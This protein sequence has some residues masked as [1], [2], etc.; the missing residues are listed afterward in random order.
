[1]YFTIACVIVGTG[2][3]VYMVFRKSD[4][5]VM[6]SEADAY[7]IIEVDEKTP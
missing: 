2:I 7:D 5:I 4:V 1:M 3:V 6:Q